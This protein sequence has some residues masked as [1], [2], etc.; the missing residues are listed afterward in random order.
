MARNPEASKI[1]VDTMA[2]EI[3]VSRTKIVIPAL[4]PEIL[5]RGR[6]LALFDNLLDK[7]LTIIA[8]PAGYGKTSLLVDFARQS[9][10]PTCWLSLDALDQ[11]PQR[12]CA[13]LIAALEQRFPKFGKQSKAVLRSLVSLEQ[14]MERILSALVNEIDAQI[15]QHFTLVVDD[16]QFV[17]SVPDIRNLFSRFI[18]LVG[19]NCHIILCSRRVPAL[20]DITLMVARQQ[21]GGFDLQELAFRPNEVRALFESNYGMTLDDRLVDGLMQQTEGWITGLHLADGKLGSVSG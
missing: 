20:P 16:Y 10:I 13:Y 3:P 21:V 11:D 1:A 17:D 7:K 5:H 15:D 2:A 9:E 8:A 12:F 4:R 18:Y 14:D 19:E 6:L